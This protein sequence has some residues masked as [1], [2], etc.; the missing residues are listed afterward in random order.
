MSAA[1]AFAVSTGG[2]AAGGTSASGGSTTTTTTSTPP[3]PAKPVHTAPVTAKTPNITYK[4]PVYERTRPARSSPTCR[5]RRPA[6]WVA[7]RAEAPWAWSPT[8]SPSCSCRARRPA[9]SKVSPRRRCRRPLAV[10]DIIW[11]GNQ[12]VGLPYIYGGGHA[13]FESPGYDCS[14]TVSF[15]LHGASLLAAPEDSSEFMVV[16]LPRGRALGHD[17]LE[18]RSRLHDRRGAAA[19]HQLGRRSVKPAGAALAPAASRQRRLHRSSPARALRARGATPAA[20]AASAAAS[21]R[22]R[23]R[24]L[25]DLRSVS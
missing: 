18:P 14:G 22:L 4:G 10:Q 6:W 24:L 21:R 2:V 20:P 5:R 1:P 16:G 8:R 12:I 19:G 23:L 7:K 25:A 15:A 3:A 17:L 13:S 9:T 11:A